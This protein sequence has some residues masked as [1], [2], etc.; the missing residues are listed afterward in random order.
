MII[1]NPNLKYKCDVIN[2]SNDSFEFFEAFISYKDNKEYLALPNK[3]SIDIYTFFDNKRI[4]SLKGH[5]K[6]I[7]HINYFIN[8]KDNNEYLVSREAKRII[9]I[10]DI[11]NNYNIK[12]KINNG[13]NRP[14]SCCLLLFP[15]NQINNYIIETTTY[16]N[17]NYNTRLY[18]FENFKC[19]KTIKS[20][21]IPIYY[22]ISWYNK[23]NNKNYIIELGFTKII[24]T[25]LLEDELYFKYED[26]NSPLNHKGFIYENDNKDY[27][28]I[29]NNTCS[30]FIIIELYS[31]TINKKIEIT[32]PKF[33]IYA[34]IEN[35]I[36][37]NNTY[38]IFNYKSYFSYYFIYDLEND[39][40]ISKIRSSSTKSTFIKKIKHPIYGES[41][42]IDDNKKSIKL[43]SI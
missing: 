21:K 6:E 9:I 11:T 25:N 22:L 10:W 13:Y 23:K 8:N 40:I 19:I 27:L 26:G 17:E 37:W 38:I 32:K 43:W 33:D 31:L 30:F 39:K 2:N 5:E 15:H 28:C 29:L 34:T 18:S 35:Y 7:K 16:L 41:L 12:Y 14:I 24:I 20:S 36:L 4:L 42:L 1:K 3:N